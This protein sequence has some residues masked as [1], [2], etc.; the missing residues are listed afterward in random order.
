M[1]VDGFNSYGLLP[2]C[3]LCWSYYRC[4]VRWQDWLNSGD[5]FSTALKVNYTLEDLLPV[6][7]LLIL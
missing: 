1:D 4:R 3:Q 7:E 6:W 2:L 5:E